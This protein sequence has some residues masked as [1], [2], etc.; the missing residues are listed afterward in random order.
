MKRGDLVSVTIA[1]DY[2]K[3]RPA[4]IVQAD[5]YREHPSVT[6]LLLTSEVHDWPLFRVSVEPNRI[7]GLKKRSQIMVDKAVTVPRRKIGRRLGEVDASTMGAV[8]TALSNFLG[9]SPP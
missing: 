9:L 4:L 2:G 8:S 5:D 3:P 1:G 7:N 6:V